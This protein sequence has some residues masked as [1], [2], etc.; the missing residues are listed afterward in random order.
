WMRMV[1]MADIN[2]RLLTASDGM[3]APQ[4]KVKG[5]SDFEFTE[6]SGGAQHTKIV[7][8]SGQPISIDDELK[9]IKRT[10]AE[11]LDRLDN[12]IDTRL[13]GSNVVKVDTLVNAETVDGKGN[14]RSEITATNES[15]IM[16]LTTVDNTDWSMRVRDIA[17]SLYYGRTYTDTENVKT[18]TTINN[19]FYAMIL[20]YRNS[21]DGS[22]RVSSWTE[23]KELAL[24]PNY[25]NSM[26]SPNLQFDNHNSEEVTVTIRLLRVWE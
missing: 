23:A 11:I 17:G 24:P 7:D 6:G 2:K 18:V 25:L 10:Q 1:K 13:T 5:E 26:L 3:P 19:P 14:L 22:K 4:H 12:G 9:S 20:G 15:Y 8:S 21:Q 16:L